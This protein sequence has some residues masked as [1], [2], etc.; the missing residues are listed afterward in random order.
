M[1][2]AAGLC[3]GSAMAQTG[4][5]T[6]TVIDVVTGEPIEGALVVARGDGMGGSHGGGR[7]ESGGHPGGSHGPRHAFTDATGSY[8]IEELEPG[9]YDVVCGKPGYSVAYATVTIADGETTVLDFPLEPLTFGAVAGQV[10]DAST[11]LPIAGARVVLL[12]PHVGELRSP[13]GDDAGESMWLHAVTGDDG[14]YVIENVPSGDY[15][16]R[17]MSFGY[18]RSDPVPVTVIEGE[19]AQVDFQLM[20]LTFGSLEGHVTDADTGVPIEGAIVFAFQHAPWMPGP[21]DG[22]GGGESGRWN[23]ARTDAD[24]FYRFEELATGSWTV[25][26]FSW[27]YYMGQ[28]EA[29]VAADQTTVV[30]LTLEPR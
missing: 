26:A 29:E 4:V 15:E 13:S 23:F 14:T 10:T 16:A 1:V 22:V 18:L 21:G 7:L 11:G 20:P 17:A 30:D 24:G 12:R 3:A 25:R 2:L 19:T 8:T 6:G 27:G 5:L 9:D 28:G